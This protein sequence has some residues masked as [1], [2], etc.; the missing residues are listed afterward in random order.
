MVA[1]LDMTY[2]TAMNGQE[3]VERFVESDGAYDIV[4]MD[5]EMPVGERAT[6]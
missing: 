6:P 4:L 1:R 2:D 3:A 5:V